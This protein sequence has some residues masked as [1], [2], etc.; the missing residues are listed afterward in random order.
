MIPISDSPERRRTFPIVMISILLLNVLAFVF[1]LDVLAT[2][3][4]LTATSVARGIAWLE[5]RDV[6]P[7]RRVQEVVVSGGGR[8]NLTLMRF[9]RQE[10]GDADVLFSDALG[11]PGDAKEAV[12]FAILA[13]QTVRALPA[14][15]PSCTG[16]R[17][18]AVLGSITPGAN[19][20]DL[21]SRVKM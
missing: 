5:E 19:F 2:V 7:G 16:A 4:R 6:E 14:S 15:L 13:N 3:T 10:V 9:L 18:P 12:A 11:L 20:K 1:E 21:M 8:H 17:Y